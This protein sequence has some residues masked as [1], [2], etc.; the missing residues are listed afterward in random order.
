MGIHGPSVIGGKG[1]QIKRPLVAEGVAEALPAKA[2]RSPQV[3][4]GCPGKPLGP[5]KFDR[6]VQR[7][8]MIEFSRPRHDLLLRPL[9]ETCACQRLPSRLRASGSM[10]S[11]LFRWSNATHAA[12]F[13]P[14]LLRQ[15]TQA[16]A[17]LD[18]APQG[19]LASARRR[20]A[21]GRQRRNP[22]RRGLGSLRKR[23]YLATSRRQRAGLEPTIFRNTFEKC[24]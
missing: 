19:D 22:D 16:I 5:E 20:C 11:L 6:F 18:D 3:V 14:R 21:T 13:Q 8:V 9:F 12:P 15:P 10:W 1:L 17:T 7:G 4:G 24:A 23:V 2:H